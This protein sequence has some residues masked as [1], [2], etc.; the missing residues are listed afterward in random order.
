[1]ICNIPLVDVS[2]CESVLLVGA[3]TG[4]VVYAKLVFTME[5][6]KMCLEKKTWFI[7]RT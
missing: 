5:V 2:C 4:V 1:M 3:F 6:L 7:C